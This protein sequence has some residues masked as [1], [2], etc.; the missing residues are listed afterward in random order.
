MGSMK[1]NFIKTE[2]KDAKEIF[3]RFKNK[4]FSGNEGRAIKNSSWQIA[5][6]LV[7]KIG[8]LLFTIIIA[9][10][11]LP[12][13]YGL[14]GL[15]LSTILFMGI[16]SDFGIGS[17]LMT[18]ISKTI[19]KTPEK[20]KGY[21]YYLTKYKISLVILSSVIILFSAKW[22]AGTYYSK[23][24][25]Y[26]LLAGAI[27]LPMT[28]FS[29]Y[30]DSIFTAKNNFR[31]QFIKELIVQILRLSIL[32]L[33][34]IYFLAKVS[35]VEIY[36][37]W[38]FIALS[39]C[40]FIGGVYLLIVAKLNHPFNKAKAQKLNTKEKNELIKFILPLS[41]TAFSG[42]FFGIIDQ[43][44]LG[45]YVES[46]F[47]GFYQAAFNLIAA[48]STIIAFSSTAVFP[49]FA[50]LKGKSLERG[51]KKTRNATIL[52]SIAAAIFTFTLA[53]FIIKI[54][55]GIEY[56]SAITYLKILSILLISFP[57]INLYT[58]YYMSQKRTKIFSILLV[59]STILNI[60]LNYIFINIGL[61]YSM[62]YA[63]IGACTATIISRY[64]YLGGLVLFRKR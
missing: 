46:Q 12:E 59:F 54:I 55:Y 13:I 26:A 27:Y 58:T 56:S 10:L 21:F 35:S 60:I 42:A 25:Y 5:T 14:Y 39:F 30:L 52:I 15:A 62:S 36:L 33:L 22:L 17:A 57:L 40:Y 44:M 23:P 19:D 37:L 64:F 8:S 45:H 48:A 61:Q 63:V 29:G 18:F 38:I 31:P 51:F 50:R 41:V 1:N 9:R 2:A 24:I 53:P 20:A 28:L 7:T 16:F 43:I 47:L 49:I 3:N 11:M 34:I 6:T 4:D 32:P